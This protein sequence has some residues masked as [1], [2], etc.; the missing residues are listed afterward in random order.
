MVLWQGTSVMRNIEILVKYLLHFNNRVTLFK[1]VSTIIT[2]FC[3]LHCPVA[4]ALASVKLANDMVSAISSSRVANITYFKNC[5]VP[6]L[7]P[8]L[9]ARDPFLV[10]IEI[11]L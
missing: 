8:V 3:A 2:Q 6:L 7:L 10:S 9:G 5:Q 11:L 1:N 4:T